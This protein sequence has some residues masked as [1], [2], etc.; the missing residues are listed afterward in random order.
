MIVGLVQF[1]LP[2]ST[3]SGVIRAS[4][5]KVKTFMQG[6]ADIILLGGNLW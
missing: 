1:Q 5:L 3:K 6:E 4:F 2:N